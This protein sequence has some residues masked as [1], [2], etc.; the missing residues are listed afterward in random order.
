MLTTH[1]ISNQKKGILE[2][3]YLFFT[4]AGLLSFPAFPAYL[5]GE[6]KHKI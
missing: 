3:L 4:G 1:L 2:I 6:S 5:P